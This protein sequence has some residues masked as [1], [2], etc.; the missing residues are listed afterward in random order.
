MEED[1]ASSSSSTDTSSPTPA[2]SRGRVLWERATDV[3]VAAARLKL[4]GSP[5]A[6][7]PMV[8][9]MMNSSYS[10]SM[11][12]TLHQLH[13]E[14]T[15]LKMG[16][17]VSLYSLEGGGYISSEG[18]TDSDCKITP[19]KDKQLLPDHFSD[20]VFR[21]YPRFKYDAHNEL[22]DMLEASNRTRA[23][24]GPRKRRSYPLS[25]ES[26]DPELETRFEDMLR[27]EEVERAENMAEYKRMAGTPIHYGQ[28]VQLLH[29]K[30]NKFV[31]VTVKKIAEVEKHC[32]RVL[33]DDEGNDGSWF[34]IAPRFK[35]RSEGEKVN[36]GDQVLLYSK[37]Y[38]LF[39]HSSP[40]PI[41]KDS[42]RRREVNA[43]TEKDSW[44]VIPFAPYEPDSEQF[45]K[46]GDI[47]RLFHK[48]AD[49]YVT[50]EPSDVQ[51]FST[52]PR[53]SVYLQVYSSAEEQ[54]QRQMRRRTPSEIGDGLLLPQLNSTHKVDKRSYYHQN[55][56]HHRQ[57]FS[58]NSNAL[59]MLEMER[60]NKGGIATYR[61]CF[62]F[63]HIA[64]GSYLCGDVVQRSLE[65][66][67]HHPASMRVKAVGESV[68]IL[69]TT[70]DFKKPGTLFAIH[71]IANYLPDGQNRIRK[72]AFIRIQHVQSRYWIHA[73]VET[74]SPPVASSRNNT[75]TIS[76][77]SSPSSS[78]STSSSILPSFDRMRLGTKIIPPT[79]PYDHSSGLRM[80]LR[81]EAKCYDEDV[82]AIVAT[83]TEEVN[84]LLQVV[85]QISVIENY[86]NKL[87]EGEIADLGKGSAEGKRVM[88]VLKDLINSCTIATDENPLT[89]EG[90]PV[91]ARQNLLREQNIIG[92]LMRL[93]KQTWSMRSLQFGDIF[94]PENYTACTITAYAY[95]MLRQILKKNVHN[96]MV[97]SK[98]VNFLQKRIS[99]PQATET[100]LELFKNN[101]QLLDNIGDEQIYFFII[102]L[103]SKGRQASYVTFLSALCKCYHEALP[104]NQ[105][106]ICE[107][108]LIENENL[109]IDVKEDSE[110]G[111]LLVKPQKAWMT[112]DAF[113]H[114]GEAETQAF[115]IRSIK[116][117]ANLCLGRNLFTA[118]VISKKLSYELVLRCIIDTSLP[119]SL[120]AAF[121]NLIKNLYVDGP[122]QK[123]LPFINYT[124]VW[125]DLSR[126]PLASSSNHLNND[127]S[128]NI[129]SSL[130]KHKADNT[131]S[132]AVKA[133]LTTRA[134]AN[135]RFDPLCR[136]VWKHIVNASVQNV[137]D[138]EQ[139]KLTLA[140]LVLLR[141]MF[142]FGFFTEEEELPHLVAPLLDLLDLRTD[143]GDTR[144]MEES[145][146][147]KA[148]YVMKAKL[149][150]CLILDKFFDCRL[151]HRLTDLL[152]ILKKK[153]EAKGNILDTFKPST[154]RKIS[155][156]VQKY[157]LANTEVVPILKELVLC[158]YPQL[159]ICAAN[160]LA[161]QFSQRAEL[162]KTLGQVQI[163]VTDRNVNTYRI[164]QEKLDQARLFLSAEKIGVYAQSALTAILTDLASLCVKYDTAFHHNQRILRN[165]DAHKVALQVIHLPLDQHI[166]T[167]SKE[168]LTVAAYFL[169]VFCKDNA[170]NQTTLFEYLD[171]LLSMLGNGIQIASTINEIFKNNRPLCS[172]VTEDQIRK[173]IN[174]IA[175]GCKYPR[176]IHVLDTLIMVNGRP[177]RR[178]QN[179]VLKMLM[180]K[181]YET[182]VLFNDPESIQ[183]RNQ[184]ILSHDHWSN[185]DSL[186]K[187]HMAQI[188]LITK[189][190]IGRI[191]EAEVKCQSLFSIAQLQQQLTDPI[192]LRSIKATFIKFLDE[193]YLMAERRKKG[194]EFDPMLWRLFKD[195]FLQEL[196][197]I[198]E[199]QDDED[200]ERLVYV[201]HSVVGFLTSYYSTYYLPDAAQQR[202]VYLSNQIL[203]ALVELFFLKEVCT[204]ISPIHTCMVGQC[205]EAMVKAGLRGITSTNR[206]DDVWV[207]YQL[208][209]RAP[210]E[211]NE[212]DFCPIL[213]RE[214]K[215]IQGL[216]QFAKFFTKHFS[217]ETEL[218][219]F[220][221]VIRGDMNTFTPQLI[222]LLREHS[223]SF[224]ELTWLSLHSMHFI[225]NSA[226][227]LDDPLSLQ[228]EFDRIGL[229]TLVLHLI[230]GSAQTDQVVLEA[231]KVGIALLNGGNQRVQDTILSA[232]YS[233]DAD[234]F[235]ASIRS[236]IRRSVVEIKEKQQYYLRRWE[237]R[238]GLEPGESSLDLLR[239]TGNSNS[240]G[241]SHRT[242]AMLQNNEEPFPESGFIKEILRFLQLLCEGHNLNLQNYLR[243]QTSSSSTSSSSP[244]QP[245]S[246]LSSFIEGRASNNSNNNSFESYDLISETASYLEALERDIDATNIDIAIQLF[247]TLTEYCQGPCLDNQLAL[248]RT[249][250][251]DSV[252]SILQNDYPLCRKAD[253]TSL[254]GQ[255]I[256]TLLALLEGCR[257]P[258]VPRQ[259]ILTL[260]FKVMTANLTTAITQNR[261][262][263]DG[264]DHMNQVEAAEAN[265]LTFA[266][267]FLAR[268]L[269]D[270]DKGDHQDLQTFLDTCMKEEG[271]AKGMGRIE[272]VRDSHLERVYFP[273]PGLCRHLSP[274][275]KHDLL[276]KVNRENQSSKIEDF[277]MRSDYL[278]QEME[279]REQLSRQPT[280]SKLFHKEDTLRNLSFALAILINLLLIG[281]YASS[282][283]ADEND[284]VSEPLIS[285]GL[286]WLIMM[287]GSLQIGV[288]TLSWIL[289][290]QFRGTLAVQKA[291]KKR[292]VRGEVIRRITWK[293]E[294][295]S[296]YYLLTNP[297]VFY[298]TLYALFGLLGVLFSPFFFAFQLLDVIARSELLKYVIKSVTLNG[299]SIVLTAILAGIVIYIYTIMGFLFFRNKFLQDDVF[300]CESMFMCLVNVVNYGLRSGGGVGDLLRPP[301]WEEPGT[302]YRILYDSTFFFLVIVI[303]LNIIFGIIIDTFGELRVQNKAIESDITEKCFICGIDRT[304]FDRYSPEGL[305]SSLF[306]LKFQT[307]VIAWNICRICA[308]YKTGPQHVAL[309]LLQNVSTR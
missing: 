213:S 210:E 189:C 122:S 169:R 289:L 181:Q 284:P 107:K 184:L 146:S 244:L 140:V 125:L 159:S 84:N 237:L 56:G 280:M 41:V 172:Q 131:G 190:A 238:R 227:P 167:T 55:V 5:S 246:S 245:S 242:L 168:M 17:C 186:L 86:T 305:F 83:T 130:S 30:S 58:L 250:L 195:H 176:Y 182:M 10:H 229:T 52:A 31:T 209:L 11:V 8:G 89:R 139:N 290:L 264:K 87:A 126:K 298:S 85:G 173:I 187:F 157:D 230:S 6:L 273:I 82:F 286:Y 196:Q 29:A 136:F 258:Y 183:V 188:E 253:V 296:V 23:T 34:T 147:A 175:S 73:T 278:L 281:S 222:R 42:L 79:M 128:D 197:E 235:V 236:R 144:I 257:T 211:D 44:R 150:A 180:E 163:L 251:C 208:L 291:W 232:F 110:T 9:M 67:N 148:I 151:D 215:V 119:G 66:S 249:K 25:N 155:R 185:P 143:I 117:F 149:N 247:I 26:S 272:I 113:V 75:N 263:N 46:A 307:G 288:S 292:E 174:A 267:L 309:Y 275:S 202:H 32:L 266:Y 224:P 103:K 260:D 50:N 133:S 22:Q 118:A 252:N 54:R 300:L 239:S 98:F 287:L 28:C 277:F 171:S 270:Y 269:K 16:D 112:L 7:G 135:E 111:N 164:V 254:H 3:A 76:S 127:N 302:L 271:L 1:A 12:E 156:S 62:R 35:M 145:G 48:E 121:C 51:H 265:P 96:R 221:D 64:S 105:N 15:F 104:K 53:D 220:A 233:G 204:N 301:K 120:R 255:C 293:F 205:V 69:S 219:Q 137:A 65:E 102:L 241:L 217:L 234:G 95:R 19:L 199:Q 191:Y 216:N 161:R 88:D 248:I 57:T 223:A 308:A 214:E 92:V 40:H 203:D 61:S 165:L 142:D 106:F 94:K 201:H 218:S 304:T 192:N 90:I 134:A 279:H 21:V 295:W 297:S 178:N 33:L 153:M 212:G 132:G 72:D 36:M 129:K 2:K 93:L 259:M 27:W 101:R 198:V 114:F 70:Y 18:F 294:L 63:K 285:A 154:L 108:L 14:E 141:Q 138:A 162:Q 225:L 59:W 228:N 194:I 206:L 116:L 38:S 68:C 13:P 77:S 45:L 231:L 306:F 243:T 78:A 256:T 276:W 91:T 80:N 123:A 262:N 177:L 240:S 166:R 43:A 37:R 4:A 282:P 200:E 274:K 261:I 60:P 152:L 47:V 268:T 100:L 207:H 20:C 124:R 158:D 39:L 109:L 170:E 303:L 193:V 226:D 160:L 81:G 74:E 49:S 179:L 299:K 283:I 97:M 99:F 24:V 71:P 115:F